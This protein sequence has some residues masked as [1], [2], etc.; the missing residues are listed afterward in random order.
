MGQIQFSGLKTKYN[1]ILKQSHTQQGGHAVEVIFTDAEPKVSTKGFIYF[2][3]DGEQLADY[4]GYTTVYRQG[5]ATDRYMLSDYGTVYVEP[6]V[7]IP[8]PVPEPEP[9]VPTPD[10]LR[11]MEL[12]GIIST[13]KALLAESD[14]KVIKNSEYSEAG[15]TVAYDPATVNAERQTYRDAINVAD[16]EL[17]TLTGGGRDAG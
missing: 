10:E 12:Q 4:S 2:G 11:I 13:N 7:I 6:V 1:A 3:E 16:T 17:A 5:Y 15:L 9:Y 8:E 14:Y